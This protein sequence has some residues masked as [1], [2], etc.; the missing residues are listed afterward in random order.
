[1]GLGVER[2][3]ADVSGRALV[4]LIQLLDEKIWALKGKVEKASPDDPDLADIEEE[5]ATCTAVADEL[6]DS[7]AIAASSSGNLPP[8][9]SLVRYGSL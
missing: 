8:Y 3:V 9:G 4:L 1:M 5:L 7:Y 6:R 2:T